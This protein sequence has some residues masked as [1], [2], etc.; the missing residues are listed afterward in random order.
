MRYKEF[1]NENFKYLDPNMQGGLARSGDEDAIREL[2]QWLN[3]N[4]YNAGAVDG[5]YGGRTARAVRKFQRDA[6]LTVDGDAGPMTITAMLKKGGGSMMTPASLKKVKPTVDPGLTKGIEDAD[7]HQAAKGQ[8]EDFLGSE[9]SDSDYEMLIRATAA[10]ASP[11]PKERAGVLAVM[12]N[13]V[14]SS[15]YP[16]S[17]RAVLTQRNQ[18]QAVTGT[19]YDPGPSRNFSGMSSNTGKEVAR[20]IVQYLRGMDKGWLNFTA[21]N[22]KAYGRGTNID[23]MYAMRRSP[24]AEVIGQT[25]FGTA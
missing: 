2:Q 8:M 17:V 21:N 13:R 11:N 1:V 18:F 14:R 20:N 5:K 12:L 25:V 23:F 22:P 6:D 9:I 7:V 10:E 19:R 24:G 15:K 3:S 16:S 4:G